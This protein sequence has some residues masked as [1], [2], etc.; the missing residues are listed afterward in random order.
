[1]I[2]FSCSLRVMNFSLLC[3]SLMCGL[4][5]DTWTR[6]GNSKPTGL[7]AARIDPPDRASAT[8]PLPDLP[9]GSQ[10]SQPMPSDSS[11]HKKWLLCCRTGLLCPAA[12][13]QRLQESLPGQILLPPGCRASS[14]LIASLGCESKLPQSLWLSSCGQLSCWNCHPQFVARSSWMLRHRKSPP[15]SLCRSEDP[16]VQHR[17]C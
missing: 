9:Q 5:A 16:Q 3:E 8:A 12:D 4:E 13:S 14:L 15:G 11:Q 2:P 17:E 10:T 6:L 7:G 1:M